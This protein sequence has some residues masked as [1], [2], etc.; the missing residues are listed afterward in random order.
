M[1]QNEIPQKENKMKKIFKKTGNFIK[2]VFIKTKPV[3]KKI[4]QVV[5]KIV[6][7][8]AKLLKKGFVKL[9][10]L[11]KITSKKKNGLA[12]LG[13]GAAATVAVITLV[14]CLIVTNLDSN[15]SRILKKE[16]WTSFI[17]Y[18]E[19]E[20]IKLGD[21][22][23]SLKSYGY[24]PADDY[25]NNELDQR[26]TSGGLT[27]EFEDKDAKNGENT[28]FFSA[29]NTSMTKKKISDCEINGLEI[30]QLFFEKYEVILPGGLI[31]SNELTIEEIV[32][33]WGN[34]TNES[35]DLYSWLTEE[36][37][38][39]KIYLDD[40]KKIFNLVYSVY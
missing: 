29:L 8:T 10:Q 9:I 12:I 33:V 30:P 6:V 36:Q 1:N 3:V 22:M 14:I 5:K 25:Y 23:S 20:T 4:G 27:F 2:K 16:K 13:A 37:N 35:E 19:G 34:P 32:K 38:E 31:L 28:I 39:I 17:V 7:N 21:K 18:I 40:N 11:I 15:R 26:F 24:K